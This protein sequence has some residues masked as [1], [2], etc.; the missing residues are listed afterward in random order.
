MN[1]AP[2]PADPM[3]LVLTTVASQE[4]ARALA[5]AMLEQRL[6]A[7]VQLQP[8]ASLYRWQGQVQQ[9]AEWRVL[10]KTAASR[11][12]ALETALRQAHPYELPAIVAV[13]V[14]QALPAFADW[15]AQEVSPD[16][17]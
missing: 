12:S 17:D 8:I 13:P 7:C 5:A 4:Q 3:L 10:L 1:V 11:Y 16:P 2:A 15:V 14:V 6:A 9:E